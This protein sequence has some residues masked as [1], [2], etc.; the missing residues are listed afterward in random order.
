MKKIWL[1]IGIIALLAAGILAGLIWRDRAERERT[2]AMYERMRQEA[3]V[4]LPET[5]PETRDTVPAGQEEQISSDEPD[6]TEKE[7]E[8]E[9][10]TEHVPPVI[11]VD[12][13]TLQEENPD[14]YA[15]ITIPDTAIDYPVL[16]N[17]E[18]DTFYHTHSAEGEE[19]FAGAIYSEYENA[20]DFSD[21]HTVLYG[22]NMRN[23]SMFADLHKFE[24]ET[25][26][27]EHPYVTIYTPDAIRYY[28]IF[29]AYLYDDR[30]LLDSFDCS[31]PAVFEAYIRNIMEQR[32]LYCHLNQ[33]VEVKAGDRI[34]TLSTC[35]GMGDEYRYLVQAVLVKEEK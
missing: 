30:H 18:D 21:V 11:P 20:S 29:A 14:I 10:E 25:F 27:D 16:H 4:T 17:E 28:R 8:T 26:F 7:T 13:E 2:E 22:H 24:D 35:H 34:L 23:G 32:S 19:S 12:F 33:D 6:E 5:K 1:G 15:W 9:T 31:D 3:R